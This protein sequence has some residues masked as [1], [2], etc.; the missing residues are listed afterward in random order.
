MLSAGK[1]DEYVDSKPKQLDLGGQKILV[2][3]L[4][5]TFYAVDDTCTHENESL[6]EGI[7]DSC[8]VE[9]P[10]HGARFDLKTGEV[11]ALPAVLPLKTYKVAVEGDVVRVEI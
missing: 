7:V 1:A 4:D 10:R 6:S 8:E 2:V 3:K 9:C 11:R 5:G